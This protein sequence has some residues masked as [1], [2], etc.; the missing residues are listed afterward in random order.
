MPAR[1]AK[2]GKVMWRIHW[3]EKNSGRQGVGELIDGQEHAQ[4]LVNVMN[5]EYPGY[6]HW[7][8]S[9]PLATAT[10]G[11]AAASPGIR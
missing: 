8:V 9:E 11:R 5:R 6:F 2:G 4:R 3:V 7:S 1:K 10:E